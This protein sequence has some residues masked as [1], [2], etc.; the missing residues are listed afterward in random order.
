MAVRGRQTTTAVI[1]LGGWLIALALSI[2]GAPRWLGW[3]AF[4]A[5]CGFVITAALWWAQDRIQSSSE[6]RARRETR[7]RLGALY[8]EGRELVAGLRDGSL[9]DVAPID[10]WTESARAEVRKSLGD[11]DAA[12]LGSLAGL[13]IPPLMSIGVNTRRSEEVVLIWLARLEQFMQQ[14]G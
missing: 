4:S 7:E 9:A 6:A 1:G 10:Q 14:L 11:A 5:G 3:L 12:L 13:S 8:A 2:L